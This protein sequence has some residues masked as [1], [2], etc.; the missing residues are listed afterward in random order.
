MAGV[1]FARNIYRLLLPLVLVMAVTALFLRLLNALPSYIQPEALLEAH[2]VATV[3]EAESALKR[4]LLLPGYFPDY[5]AWPPG[6]ITVQQRP[7]PLA[8]LTIYDR[9]GQRPVLMLYQGSPEMMER[10]VEVLPALP[11]LTKETVR[12]GDV[13]AEL[14]TYRAKDGRPWYRLAWH[15]RGQALVVTT[16][17][18]QKELLKIA[19]SMNR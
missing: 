16:S 5:L 13:A 14:S 2:S 15:A 6:K 8:K 12:L 18:P 4:K 17:L 9:A 7:V 1:N 11:L 3:G 10:G 19:R